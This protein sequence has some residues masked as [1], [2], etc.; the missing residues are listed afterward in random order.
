MLKSIVTKA[1]KLTLSL[2]VLSACIVSLEDLHNAYL[3]FFIGN[4]VVYILNPANRESGGTGFHV[5]TPKGD[6]LIMTN[7]HVC[8]MGDINPKPG[9]LLIVREEDGYMTIKK[10][11]AVYPKSDLCLIEGLDGYRGLS[12]SS[13]DNSAEQKM[14]AI[15]HP[16][17]MP[18]MVSEGRVTH[19]EK[20]AIVL[21][22]AGVSK[23]Q[24]QGP[25]REYVDPF[26]AMEKYGVPLPISLCLGH[27]EA[28]Q[29]SAKIWGGNSGSPAVNRLGTV[30]GVM[31]A[32]DN[33][34]NYG[35][36]I[37]VEY[38]RDFIKDY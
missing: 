12:I 36:M 18:L 37:P 35:M 13:L 27:Y 11:V 10:I 22:D 24:C 20:D 19:R 38:I 25:D 8:G 7:K 31:F 3:R 5:K 30:I 4:Q 23:Q 34:T 29:T 9:K 6:V 26:T 1:L 17:L 32:A 28:L 2:A 33:R 21:L 15:G 16:L 14:Y